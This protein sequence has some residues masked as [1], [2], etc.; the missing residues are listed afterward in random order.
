MKKIAVSFLVLTILVVVFIGAIVVTGILLEDK[1]IAKV[2]I[3][4]NNRLDAKI[5][6]EKV[7]LS[8]LQGFPYASV[9]LHKVDIKEGSLEVAP[10]FEPGLLSFENVIIRIGWIGI[11]K[12]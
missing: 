8:L 3:Q 10:E 6:V 5:N 4:L 9:V 7:D 11:L 2:I 1:L 12:N